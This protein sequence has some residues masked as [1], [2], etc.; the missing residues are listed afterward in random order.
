MNES[1]YKRR[2]HQREEQFII[3]HRA[4]VTRLPWHRI[5]LF[6]EILSVTERPVLFGIMKY[7]IKLILIS[8]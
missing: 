7:S 3:D 5:P 2:L 4:S 1:L 8:I 6:L